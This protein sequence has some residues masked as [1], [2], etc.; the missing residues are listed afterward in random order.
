MKAALLILDIFI[1]FLQLLI[2]F[3]LRE[4]E[5]ERERE[6]INDQERFLN[7]FK[8]IPFA[9]NAN[10][11]IADGNYASIAFAIQITELKTCIKC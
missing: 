6:R 4:R 1:K 7:S 3:K 2:F 5:R 9:F 8:K 11:I 10:I